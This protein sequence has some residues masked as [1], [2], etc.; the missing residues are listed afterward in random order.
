[1]ELK[2]YTGEFLKVASLNE[3]IYVRALIALYWKRTCHEGCLL[4]V[5]AC[6]SRQGSKKKDG[7]HL[8]GRP[9]FARPDGGQNVWPSLD[10]YNIKN[11]PRGCFNSASREQI[12]EFSFKRA[13]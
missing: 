12:S 3:L 1:M 10:G 6:L 11:A 5:Q 9:E 8:I 7:E 4:K 13:A 2:I